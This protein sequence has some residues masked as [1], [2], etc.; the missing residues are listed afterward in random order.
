MSF[1][2]CTSISGQKIVE[3]PIQHSTYYT[4]DEA[5]HSGE[6]FLYVGKTEGVNDKVRSLIQFD[7]NGVDL[8][9]V[10]SLCVQVFKLTFVS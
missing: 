5:D 7:W 6:D 9:T 8:N 3:L 1:A 2:W 10:E 4:N